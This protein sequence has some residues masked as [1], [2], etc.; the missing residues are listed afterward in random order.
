METPDPTAAATLTD[1]LSLTDFLRDILQPG[2]LPDD[3]NNQNQRQGSTWHTQGMF[4]PRNLMDISQDLSMDFHDFDGAFMDG[5]D[6]WLDPSLSSLPFDKPTTERLSDVST[7]SIDESIGLGSA[8]FRR[9]AWQW[10]PNHERGNQHEMHLASCHPDGHA[11]EQA[12]PTHPHCLKYPV[13]HKARDRVVAMLL[14]VCDKSNYQRI[15]GFFPAAPILDSFISNFLLAIETSIDDWIHIPSL[16]PNECI[17]EFLAL[18]IAGGA[19]AS[20]SSRACKLGYALQETSRLAV[21]KP[22]GERSLSPT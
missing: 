11:K 19:V 13:D 18:I 9:S 8:A 22:M 21:S 17:P 2:P 3:N 6:P 14:T 10:T 1:E 7:P 20:Q 5:W 16:R 4:T 15:V 12:P